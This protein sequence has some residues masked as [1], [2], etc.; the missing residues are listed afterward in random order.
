[1]SDGLGTWLQSCRTPTAR[2]I[3]DV[4]C[5]VLVTGS[6]GK[7]SVTRLIHAGLSAEVSG[8][9]RITG[10]LPREIAPDGSMS[11][12]LRHGPAHVAEMRWWLRS[13]P[14]RTEGIVLENS[15]VSPEL[16]PLASR[17]LAPHIVVMTSLR[18]DHPE[19]WGPSIRGA[20]HAVAAGIPE[21]ATVVLQGDDADRREVRRL[22]ET[23]KSCRLLPA[24]AATEDHRSKNRALAETACSVLGF[25]SSAATAAIGGLPPD[26]GDFQI[27]RSKTT[28]LAGAFTANDPE[29]TELLF[30]SLGWPPGETTVLYNHRTDRPQRWRQ[31]KP[32]LAG[33]P[34]QRV[35]VTGDRPFRSGKVGTFVR[36][37]DAGELDRCI[38]GLPRV[39]GCG[40][41]AGAPLHWLLDR[42]PG[43]LSAEGRRNL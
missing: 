32:W 23:G 26:F 9:A 18:A 27:F 17:W 41:I 16:Q 33:R 39:F 15:A 34:W 22:L 6:R 24:S 3:A 38:R 20:L 40:N 1:M 25:R 37:R 4:P 7:S 42:Y 10:V 28:E 43:A 19:Q 14:A 36:C 2:K 29:S 12:I 35:L 31:F 11:L 21:G 30:T 8:F 5:R 13:L